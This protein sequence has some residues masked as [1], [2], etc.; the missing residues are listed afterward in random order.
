MGDLG[1]FPLA[2]M[3]ESN[4]TENTSATKPYVWTSS[5]HFAGFKFG[6]QLTTPEDI[7]NYI[8]AGLTESNAGECNDDSYTRVNPTILPDDKIIEIL[9]AHYPA[10]VDDAEVASDAEAELETELQQACAKSTG[11]NAGT[12]T[13]A[14]T[15]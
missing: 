1:D 11:D 14:A 15:A 7:G 12:G 10:G 4:V 3:K 2:P 6:Q 8:R 13:G 9:K 5:A